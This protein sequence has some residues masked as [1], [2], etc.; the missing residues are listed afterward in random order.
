MPVFFMLKMSIKT[1]IDL[2]VLSDSEKP[3][4]KMPVFFVAGL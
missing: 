3:S 1:G 2:L 4:Y